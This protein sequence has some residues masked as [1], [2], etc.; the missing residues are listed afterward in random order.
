MALPTLRVTNTGDLIVTE[1]DRRARRQDWVRASVT[2][3]FLLLLLILIVFACLAARSSNEHWLQTKE[4]LQIILPALTGLLGSSLGFYFGSRQ[5][6]GRGQ[7]E[8]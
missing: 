8:G 4:L 3:C 7:D 6:G 1:A 5:S 2:G